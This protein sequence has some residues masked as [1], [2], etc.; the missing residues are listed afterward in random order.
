LEDLQVGY[1]K[2]SEKR[3]KPTL[4]ATLVCHNVA[5]SAA[6]LEREREREREKGEE[7]ET[8]RECVCEKESERERDGRREKEREILSPHQCHHPTP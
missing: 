5:V 7:R 6:L 4:W 2:D 1:L 3:R 8:E